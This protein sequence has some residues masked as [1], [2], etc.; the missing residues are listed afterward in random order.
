MVDSIKADPNITGSKGINRATAPKPATGTSSGISQGY[1]LGIPEMQQV[2][3]TESQLSNN[4]ALRNYQETQGALSLQNALKQIDRSAIDAYKGIA[5]NYAARGLQRS[6][7]YVRADDRAFQATTEAKL[8]E[9]E[10]LKNLLDTNKMSDTQD[11]E[12]RNN[13]IWDI[14]SKFIGTE[15][16]RKLNEIKG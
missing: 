2:S 9:T 8:S 7:G 14:I 11:Q 3:Q 1:A 4:R 10:K 12:M 16:G 6:G 5:N 13:A 15:A